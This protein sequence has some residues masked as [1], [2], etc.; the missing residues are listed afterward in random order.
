[1]STA[2]FGK[3]VDEVIVV[4]ECVVKDFVA[5]G[6]LVSEE[7]LVPEELFREWLVSEMIS[8]DVVLRSGTGCSEPDD[9]GGMVALL[10]GGRL[11]VSVHVGELIAWVGH[12]S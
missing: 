4:D 12:C 3:L 9:G 10:V 8:I 7:L 11:V 6:M 2:V 5:K 1:M